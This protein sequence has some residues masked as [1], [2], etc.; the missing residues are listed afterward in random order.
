[1]HVFTAGPY[2]ERPESRGPRIVGWPQRPA[3]VSSCSGQAYLREE[4]TSFRS[5]AQRSRHSPPGSG[6]RA[7]DFP[8]ALALSPAGRSP[9]GVSSRS[10]NEYVAWANSSSCSFCAGYSSCGCCAEFDDLQ[11]Q[12][13]FKGAKHEILGLPP[14]CSHKFFSTSWTED[15]SLESASSPTRQGSP[16]V[17]LSAEAAGADL[18]DIPGIGV[19]DRS[20]VAVLGEVDRGTSRCSM[21]SESDTQSRGQRGWGANHYNAQDLV[22]QVERAPPHT[23]IAFAKVDFEAERRKAVRDIPKLMQPKTKR[24]FQELEAMGTYPRRCIQGSSRIDKSAKGSRSDRGSHGSDTSSGG[25][26]APVSA[27]AALTSISGETSRGVVR[28]VNTPRQPG[29]GQ[30]L[31]AG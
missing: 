9:D 15:F 27:R 20:S 8:A 13:P 1:M 12:S 24:L 6:T 17:E 14:A 11:R 22:I 21:E 31:P 25:P 10:G 18:G 7:E 30:R 29:W 19:I 3:S 5:T 2:L 28:R 23:C 4:P 26:V 16:T